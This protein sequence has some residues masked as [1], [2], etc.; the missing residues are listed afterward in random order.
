MTPEQ[1]KTNHDFHE[2]G[3][4]YLRQGPRGGL[5]FHYTN[6]RRNGMTKLWK[7]RPSQFKIPIKTGFRGPYWYLTDMNLNDFHLSSECLVFEKMRELN[8]SVRYEGYRSRNRSGEV[9]IAN[10]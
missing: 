9:E 1:A 8:R 2:N 3:S 7:T 6:W 4:C 10:N 5:V